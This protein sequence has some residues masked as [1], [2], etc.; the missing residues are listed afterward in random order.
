MLV[1]GAMRFFVEAKHSKKIQF[2]IYTYVVY[3]SC[4]C[5]TCVCVASCPIVL[6]PW[7]LIPTLSSTPPS[8]G[9][10]G[11]SERAS[12]DHIGGTLN[13]VHGG[14]SDSV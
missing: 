1:S 3:N 2:L 7:G 9:V 4:I 5:Y 14:P 8:K 11:G 6:D 13:S 10:R 12:G